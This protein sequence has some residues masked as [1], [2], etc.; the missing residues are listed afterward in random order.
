MTSYYVLGTFVGIEISHTRMTHV[1]S[2]ASVRQESS[3]AIDQSTSNFKQG[4]TR[5]GSGFQTPTAPF[6]GSSEWPGNSH[7]ALLSQTG[8][9][10]EMVR[11]PTATVT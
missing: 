6:T 4:E 9:M 7:G 10:Q 1:I 5:D 11:E 8:V 3:P 2:N